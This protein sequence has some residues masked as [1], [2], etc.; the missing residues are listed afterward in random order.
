MGNSWRFSGGNAHGAR[1]LGCDDFARRGRDAPQLF[2]AAR[3]RFAA[4]FLPQHGAPCIPFLRTWVSRRGAGHSP[5]QCIIPYCEGVDAEPMLSRK[6]HSDYPLAAYYNPGHE[7]IISPLSGGP[8]HVPELQYQWK[9]GTLCVSCGHLPPISSSSCRS[10]ASGRIRLSSKATTI[11][12][13]MCHA[14]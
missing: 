11:A 14:P 3:R 12:L 8:G 6:C 7:R 2:F 9:A 13:T 10:S 4:G 5:V 1:R